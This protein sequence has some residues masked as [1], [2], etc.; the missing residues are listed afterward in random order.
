MPSSLLCSFRASVHLSVHSL[1]HYLSLSLSTFNT[2]DGQVFCCIAIVGVGMIYFA[3]LSV[4]QIFSGL[5]R[6]RNASD[7]P[8]A[9]RALTGN[10]SQ[11]VFGHTR[12]FTRLGGDIAREFK[13]DSN[14]V[15]WLPHFWTRKLG[16]A[17]SIFIWG[18]W[19]VVIQGPE[20]VEKILNETPLAEGWAWSPPVSLLGKSCLPLLEE[21]ERMFLR[22]LLV[23]PLSEDSVAKL[24]PEFGEIAEQF[25]Q[26]LLAGKLQDDGP[27]PEHHCQ[28]NGTLTEP[29]DNDL[30]AMEQGSAWTEQ[31]D[32][33]PSHKISFDA[34]RSYTCDLVDGPILRMNKWQCGVDRFDRENNES[35]NKDAETDDGEGLFR[36][37]ND[38]DDNDNDHHNK[39]NNRSNHNQ[40]QDDGTNEIEQPSKPNSKRR[41]MAI[42]NRRRRSNRKKK[43]STGNNRDNANKTRNEKEYPS[44]ST[45]MLWM[46]RLKRAMCVVKMTFGAEWMY[47]WIL[48][49]YGR[50]LNARMYLHKH[51]MEHVSKRAELAPVKRHMGHT[52]HEPVATPFP[53]VSTNTGR[54][55]Y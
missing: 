51:I 33:G 25:V 38:D 47:V 30:D 35:L 16:D 46:E 31:K 7:L 19:R 21:N 23:N 9:P 32:T 24:A 42:P 12:L 48:N 27:P 29:D 52:H 50:A 13:P 4:K 41:M 36:E 15:W 26:D 17:F 11:P 39:E 40:F 44:K 10:G 55:G 8:P 49:E 3:F 20:R 45:M 18:Q 6:D 1:T 14:E 2:H 28:T 54:I 43:P 37:D 34:L 22:E 5:R 53:I